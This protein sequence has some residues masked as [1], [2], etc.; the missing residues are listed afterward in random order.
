M[1]S[2]IIISLL[3]GYCFGFFETG[4]IIGKIK[5]QDLRTMG[6]GNIG[7]TNAMRVFGK[8]AGIITYICDALKGFLSCMVVYFLFRYRVDMIVALE[9]YAALGAVL[10]HCF[11]VY[12]KFKG[13]K[14]VS[15]VTGA[16]LFINPVIA[17]IG[18][19]SFFITMYIT[20][21]VSV[22][23]LVMNF[24]YMLLMSIASSFSMFIT[25]QTAAKNIITLSALIFVIIS[26]RHKTNIELLAAG[27]ERKIGQNG[28]GHKIS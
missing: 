7:A 5:K 4:F 15:T 24:V 23:S 11:P 19:I 1:I 14:G 20:S 26:I 10:G 17:I 9:V 6:S 28:T 12:L 22:G 27:K 3:I 25:S 2:K 13:G 8:K 16:M 18:I 21:Y